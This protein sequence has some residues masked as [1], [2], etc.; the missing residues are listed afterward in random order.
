MRGCR[1]PHRLKRRHRTARAF[2][3]VEDDVD[4]SGWAAVAAGFSVLVDLEC[5]DQDWP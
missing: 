2:K 3:V 5:P 1:E 4:V